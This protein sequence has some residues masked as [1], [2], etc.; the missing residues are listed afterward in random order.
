LSGGGGAGEGGW[1]GCPRLLPPHSGAP[2]QQLYS[3]QCPTCFSSNGSERQYL[4]FVGFRMSFASTLSWLLYFYFSLHRASVSSVIKWEQ[5]PD[6][7]AL[8][9]TLQEVTSAK[10]VAHISKI[11][12][13]V[14]MLS[15]L[16]H[17]RG[18]GV[19]GWGVSWPV[20]SP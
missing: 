16:R 8:L 20:L 1:W 17:C 11:A 19:Q 14:S 5:S 3:E 10:R 4:A 15:P 7:R 9:A 2:H 13:T 6:F 18:A 12:A